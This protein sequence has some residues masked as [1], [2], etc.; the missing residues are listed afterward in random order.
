M[1]KELRI[2]LT[3]ILFC[4]V[5]TPD[6][7]QSNSEYKLSA[8]INPVLGTIEGKCEI[9][10]PGDSAFFLT[11][12]MNI[13]RIYADGRQVL[14]HHNVSSIN[15]YTDIITLDGT[16][17]DNLVIEYSGQVTAESYP[18]NVSSLNMIRNGLVELSDHIK[19][20]P[21]MR[22]SKPFLFKFKL[23][24]PK[25]YEAVTNL[26]FKKKMTA[27]GRNLTTWE[28]SEPSYGITMLAAPN[29]KMRSLNKDGVTIEIYYCKLPVT[30]IDSM[31]NELLKSMQI[32]TDVFGTRGTNSLVRVIYSPRSAGGYARAPLIM[33]SEN[34]ALEQRGKTFGQA[35]DFR[36]NAHEIAHYWS[37]AD[38]NTPD[39]WINE[40]LAEYSALLVS[41]I[42]I[43]KDFSGVLLDEYTDIV[44]SSKS[45]SAIAETS[46][47][48]P[49]REINRYYKPT[50]LLNG[51]S[52]KF[53]DEKMKEFLKELY[54][55]FNETGRATTSVFLEAIEAVYGKETKDS[56]SESL[57]HN[58]LTADDNNNTKLYSVTDSVFIGRWTGPLTQFGSTVKF[59]LNVELKDGKLVSTLDS[60]DQNVTGIPV[61]DL[62]MAND[63]ISFK[64]GV[65]SA[66]YKG[67]LY[68]QNS[69]IKGEFN[70]RGGTYAL[71]LIKES[72]R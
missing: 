53:G 14:Y 49:D 65:A 36:L 32:L 15:G 29:L 4:M 45:K 25:G 55:L 70:Q 10:N 54:I 71:D 34:Y 63:S 64:I 52:N 51:L 33:V 8:R 1:N 28:S 43:G 50:I 6:H 59:I 42:L 39:D 61:S 40:G 44:K 66:N 17:P 30:Y 41:E 23:D 3:A 67:K 13:T 68:R 38:T 20:F 18:N 16:I 62:R 22:N 37:R 58:E 21:V 47:D 27:N 31:K 69:T 12:G 7:A 2:F 57:Y 72:E 11:K 35:R 46:G 9:K 5:M 56:F 26:I 48:S 24:V 60:P 19:W